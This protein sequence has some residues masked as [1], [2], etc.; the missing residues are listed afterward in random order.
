MNQSISSLIY[1]S[2][3]QHIIF[4]HIELDSKV[5]KPFGWRGLADP[6]A[7]QKVVSTFK[8]TLPIIC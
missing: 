7:F 1:L 4:F 2:L 8:F 5:S 6:V 3:I